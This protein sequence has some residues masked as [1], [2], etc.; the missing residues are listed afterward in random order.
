MC[1]KLSGTAHLQDS[2][3]AKLHGAS[4]WCI[5]GRS[6]LEYKIS[7]YSGEDEPLDEIWRL[8]GSLCNVR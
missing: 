1:H 2:Q 7:R 6:K 5:E 3:A 8:Y 4:C